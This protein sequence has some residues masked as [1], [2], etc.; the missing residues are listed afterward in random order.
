[1]SEQDEERVR[2]AIDED[3]KWVQFL[4]EKSGISEAQAHDLIKMLGYDRASLVREA[5]AVEEEEGLSTRLLLLPPASI[6]RLDPTL[7][8]SSQTSTATTP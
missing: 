8:L 6:C 3:A 7:P 1:M 4:V 5:R 2:R